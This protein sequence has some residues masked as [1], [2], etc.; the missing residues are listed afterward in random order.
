MTRRHQAATHAATPPAAAATERKAARLR[1]FLV[2]HVVA[3][4]AIYAAALHFGGGLAVAPFPP[5][6]PARASRIVRAPAPEHAATPATMAV[7]ASPELLQTAPDLASPWAQDLAA[8]GG[9][10]RP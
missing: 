8:S 6:L 7:Q 10:R 9:G 4:L 2:A 5:D 1:W 3:V